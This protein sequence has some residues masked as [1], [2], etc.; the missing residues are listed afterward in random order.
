MVESSGEAFQQSGAFELDAVQP[1]GDEIVEDDLL[2]GV[3]VGTVCTFVCLCKL[4]V[5]PCSR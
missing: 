1:C 3:I 4:F 2:I 5:C